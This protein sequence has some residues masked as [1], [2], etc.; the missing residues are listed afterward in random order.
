MPGRDWSG[1][2]ASAL[3]RSPYHAFAVDR[4]RV[5][6][7]WDH[8]S[9]HYDSAV[10]EQID[11]RLWEMLV[12]DGAVPVGGTVLD[13]GCGT[14]AMTERF[15]RH[16]ARAIGLDISPGMLGL[17]RQ[18]CLSLSN[19]ELICQD[20]ESFV[21]GPDHDLVLSSFC[22]AVD[23]Q[24]SVLKMDALSRGSC[25]LVSLG[26]VRGDRLAFDIWEQLGHP[27][28]SLEGFDPIFPYY[29]LKEL[30]REP[31][32]RTF[33]ICEESE[34]TVADMVH[35]LVHYFSLFQ[36]VTPAMRYAIDSNVLKRARDGMLTV[37]EERTVSVLR[38]TVPSARTVS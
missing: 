27:G 22:P 14:G 32:L 16:G 11:Q 30:G 23:D 35:H 10:V 9:T 17:A 3:S 25:C 24:L 4:S 31:S 29:L 37:R 36:D 15:A 19:V 8:I 5:V 1:E 28:L 34:I 7:H 2:W 6:R 26:G 13:I 33:D 21:S 18:R 20:W 12:R 38:W